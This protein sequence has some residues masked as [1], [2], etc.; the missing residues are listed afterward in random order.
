MEFFSLVKVA[1]EFNIS[2]GGIF[3][4]TNYT[5]ENAHKDFMENHMEAKEKLTKYL[6]DK[7][8]IK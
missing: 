7:N 8:I 1:K 6:I 3:V 5:N 4:V 2:I